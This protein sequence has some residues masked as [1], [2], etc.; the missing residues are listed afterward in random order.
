[1]LA[2]F[3]KTPAKLAVSPALLHTERDEHKQRRRKNGQEKTAGKNNRRERRPLEAK[4][5][6]K[7]TI[8]SPAAARHVVPC[9]N[10]Q[11]YAPRS[12]R[13]KKRNQ[14]QTKKTNTTAMYLLSLP[15]PR[16]LPL[17]PLR[18]PRPLSPPPPRPQP[19]ITTHCQLPPQAPLIPP[20][21][22]PPYTFFCYAFSFSAITTTTTTT[23]PSSQHNHRHHHHRC[24]NL[25]RN[26]C[27]FYPPPS[28]VPSERLCSRGVRVPS[29]P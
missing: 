22:S 20:T 2:V 23:T 3:E 15:L 26:H 12:E 24:L 6:K 27:V 1:M 21:S 8:R 19:L 18:L 9:R 4:T 29:A 16:P 11:H 14:F 28:A 25:Y 5:Y 10:A 13:C 17:L 7:H